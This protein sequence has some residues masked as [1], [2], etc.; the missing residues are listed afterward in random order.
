MVLQVVDSILDI[1]KAPRKPQYTMALELA[2]IL[3]FCLCLRPCTCIC[4]IDSLQ[5]IVASFSILSKIWLK[6]LTAS[7]QTWILYDDAGC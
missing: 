3:L 4:T 7:L 5:L 1:M 2:L 6:S